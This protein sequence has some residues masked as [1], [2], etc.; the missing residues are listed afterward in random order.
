[1]PSFHSVCFQFHYLQRTQITDV[2]Q[3]LYLQ[4]CE[5]RYS[6]H[7]LNDLHLDLCV[8]LKPLLE[9]IEVKYVIFPRVHQTP[10][11]LHLIK[12]SMGQSSLQH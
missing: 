10:N 6:L 7:S 4:V 11:P 8:L 9:P 12:A 5:Y 3:I 1:M 2:W